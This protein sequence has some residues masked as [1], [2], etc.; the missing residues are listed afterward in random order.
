MNALF[1][2]FRPWGAGWKSTRESPQ[3]WVGDRFR[4]E[5]PDGWIDESLVLLAEPDA[6]RFRRNL[7]VRRLPIEED[8]GDLTLWAQ[9]E[10]ELLEKATKGFR[11]VALRETTAKDE[12]NAQT[13]DFRRDADNGDPLRQTELAAWRRG[14]FHTLMF[15][16]EADPP[17]GVERQ[18]EPILRSF[19][20]KGGGRG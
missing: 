16:A 11:L 9:A 3:L 2:S 7:V 18:I 10:V 19:T 13:I 12:K 6:E 8:P 5:L 17:R 15:T 4:I 20:A 1:A 14:V